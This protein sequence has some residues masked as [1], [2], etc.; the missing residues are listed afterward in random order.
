MTQD[1][2]SGGIGRV[3]SWQALR[4][5]S[6]FFSPCYPKQ[7]HN[8]SPMRHFVYILH[9]VAECCCNILR[10]LQLHECEAEH[11]HEAPLLSALVVRCE[12]VDQLTM[13]N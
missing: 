1:I 13:F 5:F 10:Q 4:D 11:E 12:R 8:I 6:T 3:V 9:V 2:C 7:K